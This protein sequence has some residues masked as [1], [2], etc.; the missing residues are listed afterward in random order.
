M[1]CQRR[2]RAFVDEHSRYVEARAG[3]CRYP[4]NRMHDACGR[5]DDDMSAGWHGRNDMTIDVHIARRKV[6]RQIHKIQ[7]ASVIQA[8]PRLLS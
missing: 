1:I 3:D 7:I 8:V 5:G 6:I 4:L 2:R